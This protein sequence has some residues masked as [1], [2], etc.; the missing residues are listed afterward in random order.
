[1]RRVR[2][3]L[4]RYN[5]ARAAN[6]PGL[7]R[8]FL[9]AVQEQ[10]GRDAMITRQLPDGSEYPVRLSDI[11]ADVHIAQLR[12]AMQQDDR[13]TIE[14]TLEQLAVISIYDSQM[15]IDA[16]Y[17]FE[18]FGRLQEADEVYAECLG[19]LYE[20]LETAP[21]DPSLLNGVA[22]FCA[23]TGRNLEQAYQFAH[24]AIDTA[25]GNSALMDTFAEAAFRTNHVQQAIEAERRGL[26]LQRGDL[27]MT[28]QLARFSAGVQPAMPRELCRASD[29]RIEPS[30]LPKGGLEIAMRNRTSSTRWALTNTA[31]ICL[32]IRS[33]HC[34]GV[35]I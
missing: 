12:Q 9:K 1:M 13:P 30:F 23:R 2:V 7:A 27:F 26:D 15:A 28:K 18:Q 25:P 31:G 10:L 24:Q 5:V 32:T 3:Y 8:G 14:A 4:L 33:H 6:E 21:N 22:W 16:I 35:Q 34:E 20:T 11:F 29:G 17:L 19:E